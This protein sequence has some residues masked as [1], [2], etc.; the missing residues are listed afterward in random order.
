MHSIFFFFKKKLN[1]ETLLIYIYLFSICKKL[2]MSVGIVCWRRI[3][4][5]ND[6][7]MLAIDMVQIGSNQYS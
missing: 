6:L 1:K 3:Q 7:E 4:N 5:R 2:L